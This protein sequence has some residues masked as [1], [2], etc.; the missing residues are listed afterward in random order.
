[1]KKTAIIDLLRSRQR[2]WRRQEPE[3]RS[4]TARRYSGLAW[5]KAVAVGQICGDEDGVPT[6]T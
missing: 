5:D 1:M 4:L 2:S 3:L 6:A